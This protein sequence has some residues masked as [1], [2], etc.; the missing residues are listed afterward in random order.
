MQL[1]GW[2]HSF[3]PIFDFYETSLF[4]RIP[5]TQLQM[6]PTLVEKYFP[7]QAQELKG[8]AQAFAKIGHA[9]VDFQALCNWVYFHELAHSEFSSELNLKRSGCTALLA[10]EEGTGTVIHGRNMDNVPKVRIE[11]NEKCSPVYLLLLIRNC[12]TLPFIISGCE[13]APSFSNLSRGTGS[14]RGS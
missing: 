1:H 7:E 4:S 14:R 10:V 12:V 2:N 5:E 3:G 11:L 6:L 9:E 13:T 8:L